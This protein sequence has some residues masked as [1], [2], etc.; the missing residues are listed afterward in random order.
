[1]NETDKPEKDIETLMQERV[2]P[3]IERVKKLE[4]LAGVSPGATLRFATIAMLETTKEALARLE[5]KVAVLEK[6]LP[7]IAAGKKPKPSK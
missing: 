2:A 6:V 3:L 5:E 4:D 7:K 1:M